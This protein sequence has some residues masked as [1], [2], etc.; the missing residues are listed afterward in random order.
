MA[1]LN[2]DNAASVCEALLEGANANRTAGCRRGSI[3]FVE[4]PG[5]LIASGDLHDNPA[6]FATLV[7]AAGLGA[8]PGVPGDEPVGPGE[9]FADE[10]G[11]P[12]HL[13]LHE[14]IHAEPAP[15]HAAGR[16]GLDLSYGALARVAALKA[17]HPEHVHTLLANHEL[18]QAW[19]SDITK[20]GVAVV[21]EFD[22]ALDAVFAA[23]A[24]RVRDAIEAF[25]RS[26]PLA[27]RCRCPQGDILCA[28]SL[29]GPAMMGRFDTTILSR[30]LREADYE[31]RVG[32]AFMMVWGRGHDAEQL[33][34]LTEAWGV[35]LFIL[36][37]EHAARGYEL[38]EPN[39]LVLSSDHHRGVYL[40]VDLSHK[41][42]LSECPARLVRLTDA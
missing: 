30:E 28:H 8:A 25:V 11:G 33:E 9:A 26:M 39:A 41:P 31:P 15:P 32:S 42:R 2:L 16:A 21:Q 37:H 36:G 22:R 38:I 24:G 19:G 23:E 6:H 34:D 10:S 18:A 13:T 17:E 1:P 4:A 7:H 14:I 27:L 29:P 35:N 12:A 5:R 3:D 20:R 40:P